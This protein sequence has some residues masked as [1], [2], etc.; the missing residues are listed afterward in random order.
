[1]LRTGFQRKPA[2]ISVILVLDNHKLVGVMTMKS[3]VQI[4]VLI[5]LF[6]LS[7]EAE[8]RPTI[9]SIVGEAYFVKDRWAGQSFTLG[10]EGK[11]YY[12]IW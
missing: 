8:D 9:E 3:T 12:V 11:E 6:A 1:M 5:V 7:A 2:R 4:L 10:K